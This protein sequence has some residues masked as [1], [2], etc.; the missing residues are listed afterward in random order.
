MDHTEDDATSIR[1]D[2]RIT[3]LLANFNGILA[4]HSRLVERVCRAVA[5]KFFPEHIFFFT[6]LGALHDI[7]D[8]ILPIHVINQEH[9]GA[10]RRNEEEHTMTVRAGYLFL[11]SVHP[12]IADLILHH[13]ELEQYAT[14]DIEFPNPNNYPREMRVLDVVTEKYSSS[15]IMIYLDPEEKKILGLAMAVIETILESRKI[16]EALAR[17][18]TERFPQ[19]LEMQKFISELH[20][21]SSTS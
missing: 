6:A 2:T 5:E 3:S 12:D 10:R 15:S 16:D 20:A 21:T 13:H 18:L 9:S 11:R 17:Q 7:G 19:F 8:V 4:E 14:G 1:S